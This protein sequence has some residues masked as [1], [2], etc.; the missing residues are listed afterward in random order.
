MASSGLF[1]NV[2]TMKSHICCLQS[3]DFFDAG[4][5]P[6]LAAYC[7]ADRLAF[8]L[9]RGC[10]LAFRTGILCCATRR[11]ALAIRWRNRRQLDQLEPALVVVAMD[12]LDVELAHVADRVSLDHLTWHHDGKARWIRNHE[13]GR[14]HLRAAL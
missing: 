5:V 1:C 3:N 10:A 8:R 6:E 13:V 14:H 11:R 4:S 7:L 12:F 2:A 9:R